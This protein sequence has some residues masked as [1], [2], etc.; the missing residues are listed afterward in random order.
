MK[1][2]LELWLSLESGFLIGE[3]GGNWTKQKQTNKQIGAVRHKENTKQ[4]SLQTHSAPYQLSFIAGSLLSPFSAFGLQL[5][6]G[7]GKKFGSRL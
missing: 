6:F 5:L 7:H 4:Q 1:T 2:R 3:D